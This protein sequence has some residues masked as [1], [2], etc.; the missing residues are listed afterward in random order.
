MLLQLRARDGRT[1]KPGFTLFEIIIAM[2][3]IAGMLAILIP[4]I[5]RYRARSK[6]SSA[7][8]VL[9]TIQQG[10]DLYKVDTGQYPAKLRDLMKRPSD[11]AVKAKWQA[12]GYWGKVGDEEPN[13]PWDE[14]YQYKLTSGAKHPYELYS[15]GP[16]GRATPQDERINVWNL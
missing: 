10:I 2:T 4:T 3:I 16:E 9:R 12:Q 14:R 7:E 15:F 8:M 5:N 6:Y 13:D 11:P 1:A